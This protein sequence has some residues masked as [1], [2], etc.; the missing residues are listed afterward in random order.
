M[1]WIP[2]INAA[3]ELPDGLALP[4]ELAEVKDAVALQHFIYQSVNVKNAQ[5]YRANRVKNTVYISKV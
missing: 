4:V 2:I 5:K 1:D 3:L